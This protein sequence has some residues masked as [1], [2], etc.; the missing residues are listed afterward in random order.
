MATAT[1]QPLSPTRTS[2]L[3]ATRVSRS[4]LPPTTTPPEDAQ[5]GYGEPA[6]DDAPM[7]K[8]SRVRSMGN[9]N[10]SATVPSEGPGDTALQGGR[11]GRRRSSLPTV[12]ER[13]EIAAALLESAS[14][15]PVQGEPRPTSRSLPRPRSRSVERR[16]GAA[17][18]SSTGP[19]ESPRAHVSHGSPRYN[20]PHAPPGVPIAGGFHRVHTPLP[21][22]L[23][24]QLGGSSGWLT[25]R[26]ARNSFQQATLQNGELGQDVV[27]R[28]AV[29]ERIAGSVSYPERGGPLSSTWHSKPTHAASSVNHS[30]SSSHTANA[31][32]PPQSGAELRSDG[33]DF[34]SPRHSYEMGHLI[35][36]GG[37]PPGTGRLTYAAD[38]LSSSPPDIDIDLGLSP[39]HRDANFGRR[40]SKDGKDSMQSPDET[41]TSTTSRRA[42][43]QRAT[44]QFAEREQSPPPSFGRRSHRADKDKATFLSQ[45]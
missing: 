14:S 28:E 23:A 26:A 8:V 6:V 20:D 11:L 35:S 33:I 34:T 2:Y 21:P 3:A 31:A 25:H 40:S 13:E 22:G 29:T 15:L 44:E 36:T 24:S 37:S 32:L 30:S 43:A 9:Q 38:A 27:H 41:P 4:M 18:L 5:R 39:P 1:E 7:A 42:K 19:L 10:E 45:F 16:V 17:G 12:M